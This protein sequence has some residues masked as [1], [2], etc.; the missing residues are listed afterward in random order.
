MA[1][2][3][4]LKK[5]LI[6]I[7]MILCLL[8]TG[9]V[10]IYINLNRLLTNALNN[11]FNA[12]IISD[13]YTMEFK[14]LDVNILTGSVKVF[15][16]KMYPREKPLHD[17]DNINSTFRLGA[18]KMILKNVNLV[19][20]LR[21]NKLDLKKIELVEP[22]IDFSIADEKPVFFPFTQST[23]QQTTTSPKKSI[24]SYFLEEFK[25]TDAYF[26]VMNT[27]KLREFD[28]QRINISLKEMRIDRKPGQD[29]ISYVHFDFSIGEM[30]GKLENRGLRYF[31]FKDFNV[32]IDS[33]QVE[34]T[35]DTL[36]YHFAD[37]RAGIQNLDIQTADS[38]SHLTLESF[39]LSYKKKSIEF[40][41]LSFKPNI[42][43]A[44]MQKRFAF[45]K[46]HFA[47]DIGTI[48]VL[49]LDFESLMHQQQ[50]LIDEIR[51][52]KVSAKIYKDL[53][54]D[55]PPDH[56]PKY[57]GQQFQSISM[58]MRIGLI[59][60]TNVNLL[61]TEVKPDGGIGKA[62]LNRAT[63][64]IENVTSMPS[65]KMLTI[66]ADAY[67]ENAAHAFLQFRFDYN[68]PQFSIDGQIGKFDL[69]SLN[70]LTNSYAPARI[71]KGL[72][73]EITFSGMVYSTRSTGTMKFL[74]HD[75]IIDMELEDK[76]GWK[77]TVLGFAAN[78]YLNASNPSGN[79]PPRVVEFEVERD[80]RKGFLVM[81]IKSVLDGVKETFVM[82][83]ENKQ[84]YRET[85]Q[86]AKAKAKEER[87][88][89]KD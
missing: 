63:V 18:H 79:L 49:G 5:V 42:S 16:V 55:F 39:L 65:N 80:P 50:L 82:S 23:A 28:I 73:D 66:K 12:N 57:L 8:V 40:T 38:I 61:N 71:K 47:V 17:Y 51:L 24:E 75:L 41:N 87:K 44:A 48:Q 14:N 64:T 4:S 19:K 83:K 7:A 69:T 88:N 11:G 78:T 29:I 89:K 85:K 58:P 33:L 77:S 43:D 52:D 34:E 9:V 36:I 59:K 15:D 45:R 32:T 35:P 1:K 56:R 67:I 70:A 37:V 26:H 84:K 21:T 3:K 86:E 6:W 62:N 54:K 27:A 20:L 22:G 46:E 68:K 25:M 81:V 74:Y 10:I 72:V 13:V 60:V 30:T 76:A 53:T 31:H 2:R